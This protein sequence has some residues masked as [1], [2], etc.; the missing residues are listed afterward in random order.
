MEEKS[1]L[2]KDSGNEKIIE[3]IN[4]SKN[5]Y[6]SNFIDA[7][8]FNLAEILE[9]PIGIIWRYKNVGKNR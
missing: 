7:F 9:I 2:W 6:Y 8:L 3:D 4:K 1:K 5:K